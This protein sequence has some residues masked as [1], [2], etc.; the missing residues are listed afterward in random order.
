MEAGPAGAVA[1]AATPDVKP[2]LKAEAFAEDVAM[3]QDGFLTVPSETVYV[4]NLNENV[5]LTGA[6]KRF[7]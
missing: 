5:R 1:A 4:N 3:A 2:E 6:L 7:V